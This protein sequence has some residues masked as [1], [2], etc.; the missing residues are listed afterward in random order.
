MKNTMKDRLRRIEDLLKGEET[1]GMVAIRDDQGF[2]WEGQT[3]EDEES[4]DDAV[5]TIL[6][7]RNTEKRLVLIDVRSDRKNVMQ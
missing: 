3:Y 4:F 6:G 7:G 5:N 1:I 2:H